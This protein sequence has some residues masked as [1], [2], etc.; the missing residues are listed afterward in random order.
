M[1]V[2]PHYLNEAPSSSPFFLLRLAVV[3]LTASTNSEKKLFTSSSSCNCN[4]LEMCVGT[5]LAVPIER[6]DRRRTTRY[7][8]PRLRR[9]IVGGPRRRRPG[10]WRRHTWRW[11]ATGSEKSTKFFYGPHLDDSHHVSI[12][13]RQS[14]NVP[15][16]T[17]RLL[18]TG[19]L[20]HVDFGSHS[21]R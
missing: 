13:S 14:P 5:E 21:S 10:G 4:F 7:Q 6:S 12:T 8:N 19:R 2:Q 1:L 16:G 18:R 9:T 11:R 3:K 15:F 20:R 17:L